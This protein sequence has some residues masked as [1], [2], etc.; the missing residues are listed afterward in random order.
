[1][2][3]CAKRVYAWALGIRKTN[4]PPRWQAGPPLWQV[5]DTSG[6]TVWQVD[7]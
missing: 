3:S 1:V 5:H 4:P 2:Q 6:R 7:M